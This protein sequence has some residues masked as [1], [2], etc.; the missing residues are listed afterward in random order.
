MPADTDR[1]SVEVKHRQPVTVHSALIGLLTRRAWLLRHHARTG[2]NIHQWCEHQR[3]KKKGSC[4]THWYQYKRHN[5]A[6]LVPLHV[7]VDML[8]MRKGV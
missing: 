1:L 8:L 6:I 3:H 4:A 5:A 2:H 7:N